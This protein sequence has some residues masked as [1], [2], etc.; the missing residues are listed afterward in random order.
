MKKA[1]AALW[2][3]NRNEL[4]VLPAL[5]AGCWLFVEVVAW[6][7][8]RYESLAQV[9]PVGAAAALYGGMLFATVLNGLRFAVEFDFL[10]RFSLSR[11]AALA[12]Q[13]SLQLGQGLLGLATA[14]LLTLA[15]GPLHRALYGAAADPWILTPWWAWPVALVLPVLLGLFGGGV[16]QRFGQKGA[17]TLYFL[18]MGLC[19][20]CGSWLD[21]V[22]GRLQASPRL[23]LAAAAAPVL[24]AALGVWWLL[25]ASVR[26]G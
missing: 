23:L 5:H 22:I 19:C 13:L 9:W 17:L 8:V 10:L 11:R 1:I 3:Y 21:V 25:H 16:N 6:L 12:A 26:A 14:A 2:R 7:V 18:F 24:A 20:T 15:G 4:W